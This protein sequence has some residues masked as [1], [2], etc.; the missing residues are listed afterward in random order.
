MKIKRF[1]RGQLSSIQQKLSRFLWYFLLVAIPVTS[2]PWIAKF[3][4]G[5]VVSPLAGL[6]LVLIV[7]LWLIPS[8]VRNDRLSNITLPLL[9]FAGIA[10]LA[11]VL[12]PS[13]EIYPF[14]GQYPT[15]R[16]LRAL[17]TLG[18][19]IFFYLVASKFPKTNI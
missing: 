3:T 16:S 4:G 10:L 11:T 19:G 18:V 12:T 9:V 5:S 7:T 13:L 14:L 1:D 2:F 6:P 8:L 17:I 15:G